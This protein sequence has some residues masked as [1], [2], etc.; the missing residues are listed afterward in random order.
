MFPPGILLLGTFCLVVGNFVLLVAYVS[1]VYQQ[2][3]FELVR[4]ALLL[5][6]YFAIASVGAWRGTLQL[7]SRPHF[8]EKTE[9]GLSDTADRSASSPTHGDPDRAPARDTVYVSDAG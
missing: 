6:A 7:C 8:W 4:C 1:S 3:R 2:Q 5:P 9:H